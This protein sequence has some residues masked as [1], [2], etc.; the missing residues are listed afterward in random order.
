MKFSPFP[1]QRLAGVM[2]ALVVLGSIGDAPAYAD[3]DQNSGANQSDSRQPTARSASSGSSTRQGPDRKSQPAGPA[4][5]KHPDVQAALDAT[6]AQAALREEAENLAAFTDAAQAARLPDDLLNPGNAAMSPAA[7]L[8]ALGPGGP[9]PTVGM[10]GLVPN[11][12]ALAAY[13]A[14]TYPGVQAIG[15]VRADPLPDHPSGHAID[16]MIGSDMALGD[17]INADVQSQAG[18]FSVA[19][20]LWRVPNHFNHVHVT[21]F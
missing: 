18:R 17:A 20:T 11:A 3:T 16:I 12:T 14:S 8:A 10:G 7:Q 1:A 15:G 13:I 2:A 5:N 9:V 19:Y 6:K 21:V 4:G